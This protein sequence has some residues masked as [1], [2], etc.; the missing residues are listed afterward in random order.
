MYTPFVL[1]VVFDE[2]LS[3]TPL[4]FAPAWFCSSTM[5]SPPPYVPSDPGTSDE[6]VAEA[7]PHEVLTSTGAGVAEVD[8]SFIRLPSYTSVSREEGRRVFASS[9]SLNSN[10]GDSKRDE[11][12]TASSY[13][14][15]GEEV[16]RE[17]PPVQ[18]IWRDSKTGSVK[19]VSNFKSYTVGLCCCVGRVV[20][21]KNSNH[22][23]AGM[24]CVHV[25][26]VSIPRS[27]SVGS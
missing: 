4:V 2:A 24:Y 16:L 3:T 23:L 19:R 21:D 20:C 26:I 11:H 25:A 13:G 1:R 18:Q 6:E 7:Q 5:R 9:D 22:L 10:G 27:T 14:V 12:G 8:P 17:D 15:A